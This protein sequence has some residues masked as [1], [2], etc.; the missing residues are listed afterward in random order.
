MDIRLIIIEAWL[1]V[2]FFPAR[3]DSICNPNLFKGKFD[4]GVIGQFTYWPMYIRCIQMQ[5]CDF[6]G[7]EGVFI[8]QIYIYN[9]DKDL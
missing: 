9:L 5:R 4:L 8:R 6:Q 7:A 1:Q 2:F 3:R